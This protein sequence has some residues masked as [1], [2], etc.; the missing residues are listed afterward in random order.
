MFLFVNTDIIDGAILQG[1]CPNGEGKFCPVPTQSVTIPCGAAAAEFGRSP[2]V[3]LGSG[4][5][6]K[7]DK[8][9]IVREKRVGCIASVT[10]PFKS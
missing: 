7:V 5:S 9:Q 8:A 3:H 4:A 2:R 1:I 10:G 6:P